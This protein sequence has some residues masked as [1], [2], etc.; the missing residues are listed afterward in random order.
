MGLSR[1]RRETVALFV[2][3]ALILLVGT[4]TGNAGFVVAGLIV[5]V[6]AV[7]VGFNQSQSKND[8]RGGEPK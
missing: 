1:I 5:A 6:V 2:A 4:V 7:I 8:S 3:A